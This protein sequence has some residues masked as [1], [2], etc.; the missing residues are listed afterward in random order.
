MKDSSET[1][2]PRPNV[3]I[4]TLIVDNYDSYTYN[5]YQ[6]IAEI[7]RVEPTVIRNDEVS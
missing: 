1:A 5:L 4:K 7:N 6:M 2:E 3:G